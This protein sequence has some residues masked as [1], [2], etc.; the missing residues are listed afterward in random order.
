VGD[1]VTMTFSQIDGGTGVQ[2]YTSDNAPNTGGTGIGIGGYYGGWAT[3]DNF[4]ADLG[5]IP[6]PGAILLGTIGAAGVTWIRRRR[7]L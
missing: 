2:V 3:L 7:M 5:T 1:V 4:A 6:A